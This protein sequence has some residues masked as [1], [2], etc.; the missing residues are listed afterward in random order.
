MLFQPADGQQKVSRKYM[1][2]VGSRVAEKVYAN[3]KVNIVSLTHGRKVKPG[4]TCNV[5]ILES[6]GDNQCVQNALCFDRA[7]VVGGS[8]GERDCY[9][10]PWTG[11]VTVRFYGNP[12]SIAD[13]KETAVASATENV[14]YTREWMITL[15]KSKD[16]SGK[17]GTSVGDIDIQFKTGIKT[18][19]GQTL[20]SR[21]GLRKAIEP[22]AL[23]HKKRKP[24][25]RLAPA[26][27]KEKKK[28][29]PCFC[30]R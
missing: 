1:F 13:N 8:D 12:K 18:V 17:I 11:H 6:D 26:I 7:S 5:G 15:S 14:V 29:R 20:M 22:K 19:T 16:V 3:V 28:R 25:I 9:P 21:H 30:A 10:R 24:N 27:S 2:R 4:K 23:N